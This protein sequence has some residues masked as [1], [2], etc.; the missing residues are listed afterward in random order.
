MKT[1]F[2]HTLQICDEM[3]TRRDALAPFI[4]SDF[5]AYVADMRQ[6]HVWGDEP[7]ASASIPSVARGALLFCFT[8]GPMLLLPAVVSGLTKDN[9][10]ALFRGS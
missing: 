7:E 10:Q 9:K 8:Q 5:D 4:D 3:E 2:V 1:C 6:P